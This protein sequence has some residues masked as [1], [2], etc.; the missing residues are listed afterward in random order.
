MFS[1]AISSLGD[2]FFFYQNDNLMI[3]NSHWIM[4]IIN[5]ILNWPSYFSD[6]F[7]NIKKDLAFHKLISSLFHSTIT[8]GKKDCLNRSVLQ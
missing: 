2:K 6:E 1:D 3:L 7:L 8:K 4:Y 5:W